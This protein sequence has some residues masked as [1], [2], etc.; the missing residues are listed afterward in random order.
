MND[1]SQAEAVYDIKQAALY[2]NVV[3][4]SYST[5]CQPKSAHQTFLTPA[6]LQCV[7]FE[8]IYFNQNK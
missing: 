2:L 5:T 6:I 3:A 1:I 8:H 7:G 4:P